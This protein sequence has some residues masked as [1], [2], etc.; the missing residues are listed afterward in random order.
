MLA[1][2][3]QKSVLVNREIERFLPK[4]IDKDWIALNLGQTVLSTELCNELTKPIWDL[5]NRGGKRWRPVLMMLCCD[6]VNGGSRIMD[7]VPLIE[8]IH[9]GTLIIDDIEDDSEI[10]R[11]GPAIHK[12]YGVD[13][14]VNT[15]NMLYYLPHTILRRSRI[16][17]KLKLKIHEIVAEEMLKL[18]FGQGMDIHWHNNGSGISEQAYLQMCAYK[19]GVLARMA[20][21][22]GAIFGEATVGQINS[23]GK[24]AEAVGIAFQ[25]QDD[26]LNL[27]GNLGKEHAED[28]TEGKRSIMVIHVLENGSANDCA[29]LLDILSLKSDSIELKKEAIGIMKRYQSIKYA[30]TRAREIVTSAWEK[31]DSILAASGSKAK[32]EQFAH[33]LIERRI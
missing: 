4:K 19:T 12:K 15:G 29:R 24:F 14:A 8:L 10:R 30:R 9:N 2:L 33:F 1:Y 21:K 26:I 11:S 23:L 3:E 28:I 27:T 32:L 22:I 13:V 25:I 5:L 17:P 31:L 18:H 7:F 16:S 20:A 6:A